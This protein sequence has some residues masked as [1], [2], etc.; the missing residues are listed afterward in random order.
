MQGTSG[1]VKPYGL[2]TVFLVFIIMLRVAIGFGNVN[3]YENKKYWIL[4]F[5]MQT[6]HDSVNNMWWIPSAT[7][8]P[9]YL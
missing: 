4:K 8:L 2:Q 7:C 5:G 3:V 1:C 9:L 6:Q